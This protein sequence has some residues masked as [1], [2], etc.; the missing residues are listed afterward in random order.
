MLRHIQRSRLQCHLTFCSSGHTI[1]K[2]QPL[3][4]NPLQ[5]SSFCSAQVLGKDVY[6]E[7]YKRRRMETPIVPKDEPLALPFA[8][9]KALA[10]GLA[11]ATVVS[12]IMGCY[13]SKFRA[14][15]RTK[16]P[17]AALWVDLIKGEEEDIEEETKSG[18]SQTDDSSPFQTDLRAGMLEVKR[19]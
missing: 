16:F 9:M 17:Y 5:T 13:N 3:K 1:P 19:E 4:V 6:Q 14:Q 18:S 7:H 12:V 2:V 10:C 8:F 11:L 15:L